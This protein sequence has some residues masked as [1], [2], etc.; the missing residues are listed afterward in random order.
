M[1]IKK[2]DI[3]QA[4]LTSSFTTY[5]SMLV[6]GVA[7]VLLM[8]HHCISKTGVEGHDINFFPFESYHWPVMV[9][10]SFK[11]CV[12]MFIFITGYGLYKSFS[13]IE[14]KNKA[15]FNWTGTRLLKTLTGFWFVYILVFIITYAVNQYPHL[16]Y[17]EAPTRMEGSWIYALVDFFGL[18]Y[19]ADTPT[20]IGTWW[21]M[22]AVVIMIIFFPLLYAMGEKFS[23]FVTAFAMILLPR[24]LG[25][26][27]PGS[28][29]VF[30]FVLVFIFGMVFAKHDLF[31][32][33]DNFSI[34]KKNKLLSDI[35]LFFV[36]MVAFFLIV[37]I[38][39]KIGRTYLWEFNYCIA[40]LIVITFTN[41]YLKRIPILN[42]G[43][44]YIGKH[45]LNIFLIHTFIRY[46]YLNDFTYSF[47]YALLIP[48]ILLAIS[49]ALS[50]VVELLKKLVR[51]D[52]LTAKAIKKLFAN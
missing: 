25:Q 20:L 17:V 36:Y 27:F 9:C 32:K 7:I 8:F 16:R 28:K 18:S 22:S 42:R 15:V 52:K 46:E 30:S 2:S 31:K 4:K 29:N 21:Y 48:V 6:K 12:G 23:Y 33:L 41:R 14:L 50:V 1:F 40:P 35:I 45:S 10:D 39:D 43:L 11:L 3:E 34:F 37:W 44:M 38:T 51:Y 47:K 19:V 26:G 24:I 13:R 5:D 49:F